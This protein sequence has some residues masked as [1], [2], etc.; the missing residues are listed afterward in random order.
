MAIRRYNLAIDNHP[1]S[2]YGIIDDIQGDGEFFLEIGWEPQAATISFAR[3]YITPSEYIPFEGSHLY[4]LSQDAP[5]SQT[6]DIYDK[7]SIAGPDIAQTISSRDYVSVFYSDLST[8][9]YYVTP[10][11]WSL[12]SALSLSEADKIS[13]S[14]KDFIGISTMFLI[15]NPNDTVKGSLRYHG[16][17]TDVSLS[18]SLPALSKFELCSGVSALTDIAE[19][20]FVQGNQIV[21]DIYSYYYDYGVGNYD[22]TVENN[23]LYIKFNSPLDP[24]WPYY[25]FIFDKIP[26][27]EIMV[28]YDKDP[29]E[30]NGLWIEYKNLPKGILKF[31]YYIR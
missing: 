25:F 6:Y 19:M 18:Y 15:E 21:G 24:D 11:S 27:P 28:R 26:S 13:F 12:L 16:L 30:E 29:F 7:T 20:I 1:A 4:I 31:N 8:D 17:G 10:R 22:L 23:T 9:Y 2:G 3:Q 14:V 5:N